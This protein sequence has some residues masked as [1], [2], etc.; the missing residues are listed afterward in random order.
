MDEKEIVNVINTMYGIDIHKRIEEL[1]KAV[2]KFKVF[3]SIY[4]N[5]SSPDVKLVSLEKYKSELSKLVSTSIHIG[6]ILGF[7]SIELMN[8]FIKN[9]EMKL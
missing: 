9:N 8:D 7:S 4:K 1:N 5:A 6:A 3:Y 2:L